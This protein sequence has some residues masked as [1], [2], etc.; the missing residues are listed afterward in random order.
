V[1]WAAVGEVRGEIRNHAVKARNLGLHRVESF[2]AIAAAVLAYPKT[3]FM[4]R[5]NSFGGRALWPGSKNAKAGGAPRSAFCV[6]YARVQENAGAIRA[7]HR[8]LAS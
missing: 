3:L 2:G 6:R 1:Q 7:S 8:F 5:I 4:C